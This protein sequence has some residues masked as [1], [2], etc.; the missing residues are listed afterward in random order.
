L[1]RLPDSDVAFEPPTDAPPVDDPPALSQGG[2][3]F[4]SFNVLK[5][6][7]PEV[8]AVWSRILTRLPTSRL[9]LKTRALSCATTQRR[10]A[11]L[12][13][14]HGIADERLIFVGGTPP[15]QHMRWMQRADIALDPFPYAGGR[16][17]LE[18]LWM[19]LPVITLPRETFGSRHSLSYL[20]NIGLSELVASSVDHYVELAVD[21]ANDTARLADMRSGLR[22]RILA[23]PLCDRDRFTRN[24]SAALSTMWSRWCDSQP[25]ASFEVS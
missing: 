10:Y 20:S 14:G 7:T 18:A 5:K 11:E 16:T 9:L 17:T 13:A 6:I 15:A 22:S 24:L 12:F 21:L 4:G 25:V 23:S 2:I 1:V 3:T 8:V 19:G